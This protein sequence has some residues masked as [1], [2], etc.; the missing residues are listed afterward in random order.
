MPFVSIA[1]CHCRST[2]VDER[3]VAVTL[4]TRSETAVKNIGEQVIAK[5]AYNQA[6]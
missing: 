6:R 1:G 3:A 4:R 2:D 5:V